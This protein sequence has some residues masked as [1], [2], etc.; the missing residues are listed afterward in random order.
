M[1][2][3]KVT[4][5]T[6]A[7][8]V[9]ITGIHYQ[10]LNYWAK[11]GLI[12][13]SFVEAKGSGSRRIYNFQDLVAIRVASKMRQAGIFGKAMV[14]IVEVLHRAGFDSP[15]QVAM[16][17]TDAGEVIVKPKQGEAFSALRHPG[18]LLLEFDFDGREAA[19]EM[20]QLLRKEGLE[21]F[22]VMQVIKKP[23]SSSERKPSQKDGGKVKKRA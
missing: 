15:A 20:R 3:K 22:E 2:P 18:Q 19:Q 8:V 17:I 5:Y 11:I 9:R 21:L 12:K 13:P 6:A 7:Q 4:G 10:T 1:T 14:R 23:V 16:C